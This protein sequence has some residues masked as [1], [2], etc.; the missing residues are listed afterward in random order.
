MH[1]FLPCSI[2]LVVCT[3]LIH[4]T[5][6]NAAAPP[7]AT[8]E[9][10]VVEGVNRFGFE[11]FQ[12]LRAQEGNLICSPSSISAALAMAGAG[13]AGQ[14][15]RE[16][17]HALHLTTSQLQTELPDLCRIWMRD[18]QTEIRFQVANRLWGHVGVEYLPSFLQ[19]TRDRYQAELQRVDFAHENEAIQTINDWVA[20]QTENKITN[21]LP[22]GAVSADTKLVLT[23]AVYFRA[24][25]ATPFDPERTRQAEFF[26]PKSRRIRVPMMFCRNRFHYAALDDFQLLQLDY[27][28]RSLSMVVLLPVRSSRLADLESKLTSENLNRWLAGLGPSKEVMVYLP[29]FRLGSQFD[30]PV[31]L[32]ALGIASA[33]DASTA[34]F[35]GITGNRDLFISSVIH[36]AFVDVKEEGTEAAAATGVVLEPTA[37]PSQTPPP[38]F[39]AD[40]PFIFLIRDNRSGTIQFLGRI[41]NPLAD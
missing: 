23:N 28:D 29:K 20:E 7:V 27:G 13:A 16:I 34:D 3:V 14:T 35:S 17:T 37:A 9:P 11:L 41:T 30:L 5:E 22:A 21:L 38:T 18:Q 25:W 24:S 36:K 26:L 1:Y 12:Q 8:P 2:L 39:R 6:S 33:F 15:Q 32:Q 10:A 31:V 40:H 19:L 4:P